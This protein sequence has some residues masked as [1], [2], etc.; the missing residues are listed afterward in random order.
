MNLPGV[1]GSAR[2]K[3]KKGE[4]ERGRERRNDQV[5]RWFV[6]V[7]KYF[8]TCMRYVYV[9]V[10]GIYSDVLMYVWAYNYLLVAF[11]QW[12]KLYVFNSKGEVSH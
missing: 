4:R 5:G 10:C 3:G 1:F 9:C 6:L 2:A 11:V 8:Y 7:G 12:L